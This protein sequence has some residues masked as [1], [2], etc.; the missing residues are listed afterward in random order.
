MFP[1]IPQGPPPPL[2]EAPPS[3]EELLGP[4]NPSSTSRGPDQ[5]H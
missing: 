2:Y 1:R 5:A 4:D 3:Y